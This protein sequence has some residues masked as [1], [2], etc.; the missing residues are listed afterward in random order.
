[1]ASSVTCSGPAEWHYQFQIDGQVI[2]SEQSFP[3]GAEAGEAADLHAAMFAVTH[4][5]SV[6]NREWSY[7]LRDEFGIAITACAGFRDEAAAQAAAR[8]ARQLYLAGIGALG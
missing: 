5:V 3:S 8:K 6:T 7:V 1:M 4:T 2:S